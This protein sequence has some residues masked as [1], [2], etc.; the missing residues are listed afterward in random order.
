MKVP[1]AQINCPCAAGLP[2]EAT[3]R[4]V[5][6]RRKECN[7][8]DINVVGDHA[9]GDIGH[10]ER[11]ARSQGMDVGIRVG[12]RRCEY[13]RACATGSPAPLTPM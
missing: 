9:L 11:L 7:A 8:V 10:G 12:L 4:A 13:A 2:G 6:R 3:Q 5:G 1:F